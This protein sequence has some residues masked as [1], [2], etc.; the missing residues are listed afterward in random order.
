MAEQ[1]NKRRFF[2][3]M[4]AGWPLHRMIFAASSPVNLTCW[5]GG[6]KKTELKGN[7]AD[8]LR[9]VVDVALAAADGGSRR[10]VSRDQVSQLISEGK[11]L[12]V[13]F[14]DI[15]R[16]TVLGQELG[17]VRLIV[18]YQGHVIPNGII[19]SGKFLG[20]GESPAFSDLDDFKVMA[21]VT[22]SRGFSEVWT[23]LLKCNVQMN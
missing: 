5:H 14:A 22:V 23:A 4:L 20:A 19:C 13:R 21:I 7:C 9:K 2:S 8:D 6:G 10:F 1:D 15:Q 16:K 18:P 17:Y 12:E 3:R 11:L